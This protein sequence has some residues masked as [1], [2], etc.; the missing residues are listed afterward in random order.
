M[1]TMAAER[2]MAEAKATPTPQ[3]AFKA[4]RAAAAAFTT[5]MHT[6]WRQFNPSNP[7]ETAAA[8]EKMARLE[9]AF[10]KARK[11]QQFS[12]RHYSYQYP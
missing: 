8:F 3:E 7:E 1:A 10:E 12:E 6:E 4:R 5:F 11:A 9:A 2:R